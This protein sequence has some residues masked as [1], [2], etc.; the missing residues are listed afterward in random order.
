MTDGKLH[1]FLPT[2]GINQ[3]C[4]IWD[5]DSKPARMNEVKAEWELTTSSPLWTSKVF[6]TSLLVRI[7]LLSVCLVPYG[8]VFLSDCFYGFDAAF[9]QDHLCSLSLLD[10]AP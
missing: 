7:W 9:L 6:A 2:A 1:L 8:W 5:P 3:N 10:E 4:G